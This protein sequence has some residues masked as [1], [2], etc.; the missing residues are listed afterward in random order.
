VKFG[1]S[2]FLNQVK[3]KEQYLKKDYRVVKE[4][5]EESGFGWDNERK[6]VTSPANI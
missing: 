5:K 1:T 3:Q 2:Y 4:Q 6:M